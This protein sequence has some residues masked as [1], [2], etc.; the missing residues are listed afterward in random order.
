MRAINLPPT[1]RGRPAPCVESSMRW[2]RKISGVDVKLSGRTKDAQDVRETDMQWESRIRENTIRRGGG[3]G[4][5]L[6]EERNE[7]WV[8][9]REI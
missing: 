6:G 3:G 7:V 4:R 9:L 1:E 8:K 2:K 5:V